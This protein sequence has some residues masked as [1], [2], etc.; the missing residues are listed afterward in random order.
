MLGHWAIAS[1]ALGDDWSLTSSDPTENTARPIVV[2]FRKTRNS[3][4]NDANSSPFVKTTGN[5]FGS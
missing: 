5:I 1:A 2:L 4:S 3:I